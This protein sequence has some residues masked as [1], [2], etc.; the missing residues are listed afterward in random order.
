MAS[1]FYSRR[2]HTPRSSAFAKQPSSKRPRT[3]H[4]GTPVR[5]ATSRSH[6]FY[7]P[8]VRLEEVEQQLELDGLSSG[9][10]DGGFDLI[11]SRREETHQSHVYQDATG[12]AEARGGGDRDEIIPM[13]Q[14]QHYLLKQLLDG[15]KAMSERQNDFEEKLKDLQAKVEKAPIV[16]PSSSCDGKRKRLVTRVLSVSVGVIYCT[17]W[18]YIVKHFS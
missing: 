8:G 17:G 13:L 15:N 4:S 1:N 10:E 9:S 12:G 5:P 16:S 14:E 2:Q 11:D 18:V 3:L 6:A 7:G